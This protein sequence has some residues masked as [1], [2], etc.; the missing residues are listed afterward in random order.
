MW[1]YRKGSSISWEDSPGHTFLPFSNLSNDKMLWY[2]THEHRIHV[3]KDMLFFQIGMHLAY[4]A[5]QLIYHYSYAA[6]HS[7]KKTLWL[8]TKLCEEHLKNSHACVLLSSSHFGTL[9]CKLAA[10]FSH[11]EGMCGSF[12]S[13]I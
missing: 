3:Q 9:M 12:W 2:C 11:D 4:R 8:L 1:T 6:K 5:E 7:V 10:M 13:E